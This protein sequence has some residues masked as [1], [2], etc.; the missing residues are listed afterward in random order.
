MVIDALG[1]G[2]WS[3]H[4][5][6]EMS[7]DKSSPGK[8]G[9][10]GGCC[11]VRLP[12]AGRLAGDFREGWGRG[13]FRQ[14]RPR[15]LLKAQ[16]WG[17]KVGLCRLPRKHFAK[18]LASPCLPCFLPGEIRVHLAHPGMGWGLWVVLKPVDQQRGLYFPSGLSTLRTPIMLSVLPVWLC[19]Q[20]P[21]K[22]FCNSFIWRV[23]P[24]LSRRGLP[25]GQ[26]SKPSGVLRDP[27]LSGTA[28]PYAR[29]GFGSTLTSASRAISL[30]TSNNQEEAQDGVLQTFLPDL[31]V[32]STPFVPTCTQVMPCTDTHTH[33]YSLA[34]TTLGPA[35]G[36]GRSWGS[37][38]FVS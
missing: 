15:P 1:P 19:S 14:C 5:R 21:C 37:I 30:I 18:C 32:I 4:R 22:T 36:C 28:G 3:L 35:T 29:L 34:H 38:C 17:C 8:D 12:R 16:L 2:V 23:Q 27:N 9:W 26:R 31:P 24:D 6:R 7:G 10:P 11:K 33:T 20:W 25:R 13:A